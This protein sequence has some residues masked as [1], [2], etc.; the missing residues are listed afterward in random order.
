MAN[1]IAENRQS[2]SATIMN[3]IH[4][5]LTNFNQQQ[6]EEEQESLNEQ[7]HQDLN[8][9][10]QE[11]MLLQNDEEGVQDAQNRET[12]AWNLDA[13]NGLSYSKM[14]M[15]TDS[16]HPRMIKNGQK[17]PIPVFKSN[18]GWHCAC[19]KFRK[20]DLADLGVG[21]TVYFKMLKFMMILFLWF[22]ILSIPA[23]L[24]YYSGNQIQ[25][26]KI[27]IKNILS[28]FSLGNIGQA[29]NTCNYGNL[30]N[31][32]HVN[33]FCSYGVLDS[34]YEY[35]FKTGKSQCP[36]DFSTS[37]I[38]DSKCSYQNMGDTYFK[39]INNQFETQ[40]VHIP[41]TNYTMTRAN[42]AILIVLCDI[43]VV[44]SF[45]IAIQILRIYEKQENK[46]VNRNSLKTENFAV[47]IKQLPSSLLLKNLQEY[48]A[49]LW[50]HIEN[51]IGR[52][53]QC[54]EKLSDN[55]IDHTQIVNIH[56]GMSDYGKIKILLMVYNDVK[57]MVQ[58]EAKRRRTK[59]KKL[60]EK[61]DKQIKHRNR[62]ID[63][64]LSVFKRFESTN[65][66]KVVNAYV[67]FRS[68]EGKHRV[69]NAFKDGSITRFFKTYFCCKC[70]HY[71]KKKFLGKWIKV[72][73]AK[74]PDIILWE[75]LKTGK[76]SRFW[77]IL[78]IAIVT[79]IIIVAA[80]FII[81][82]AKN[83]ENK[84][85]DFSP[86]IECPDQVVSKQEAYDDQLK[87]KENRIG[88]MHCYCQDQF[89][90]QGI[91]I[92]DILFD[93]G[94]HYCSD[95]LYY[96][97]ISNSFIF[98]VAFVISGI[99]IFI[100]NMN[101][102]FK[103]GSVPLFQGQFKEF[104][105]EWYRVVGTTIC[106]TML[107]NVI[108][109]HISNLLFQL[110]MSCK[111]CCDRGCS[112]DR[113]KT[114]QLLQSEYE[115]IN[116]GTELLLEFRYSSI[117]TVIYTIM[118]YS[119]GLPLLYPVAF[120]SF[121][122]T[123]WFDKFFLLKLYRKPPSHTI[124]LSSQT[125]QL[126]YFALILHYVIGLYMYSNI[127]ILTPN[128]SED[129]G[130]DI[131]QFLNLESGFFYRFYSWHCIL[132]VLS[133]VLI[134][135]IILL[136]NTLGR[137]LCCWCKICKKHKILTS[138][139]DL[140]SSDFYQELSF[141]QLLKEFKKTKLEYLEY[142]ESLRT[143]EYFD[144]RI[145]PI[146]DKHIARLQHKMRVINSQFLQLLRQYN[147]S[148]DKEQI[149]NQDGSPRRDLEN[150]NI[151]GQ[152]K[153]FMRKTNSFRIVNRLKSHIYSYDIK[154]NEYYQGVYEVENYLKNHHE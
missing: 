135:V 68:M 42:L 95:W 28:A 53:R 89:Y 37:L 149:Y 84:A 63:I 104:T 112:C 5:R 52:E 98:L 33:L 62:I 24:F 77:R 50:D 35:G 154:D 124:D 12:Q 49:L 102:G 36:Q 19:N 140:V 18:T 39:K 143:G 144:K 40:Q 61:I 71:N 46:F 14:K 118:M 105:V 110:M 38:V 119:P 142:K 147:I 4:Q 58:L 74:A 148:I 131:N 101:F 27:S 108:S 70:I 44:I 6:I 11:E 116:T 54:I 120:L 93:N 55:T 25:K 10:Q 96:Y 8:Q 87:S 15:V 48:K 99:I 30:D 111:R 22:T 26:D 103:T 21:V 79:V 66:N 138:E 73:E 86:Q 97:T 130:Y 9:I 92:N 29:S 94:E 67:M 7:I 81:I 65:Q 107:I 82:E 56:F 146:I 23:L 16:R 151:D 127:T 3:R 64:R 41:F 109:P 133:A 1:N 121:F 60:L 83:F 117:L 152:L 139:S 75:N 136:R 34:L 134:I 106:L 115:N 13:S 31:Q 141:Q 32:D 69:L 125:V 76:C 91:Q 122:L 20:S 80:F 59:S 57:L 123:Y 88:L 145:Y 150:I 2:L 137:F 45:I 132:L 72:K 114:K 128:Y 17:A 43:A 129:I 113:R 47:T 51:V 100:V 90:V 126:M 153:Q 85:Q 78:L